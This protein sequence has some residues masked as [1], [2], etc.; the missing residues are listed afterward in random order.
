M[1]S[2]L[3]IPGLFMQ[4]NAQY[5]IPEIPSQEDIEK[6][7][8]QTDVSGTYTNT[9]YGVSVTLPDGWSGMASDFKDPDTG[10]WVTGFQAMDGG[11]AANMDAMQDGK[12]A[13]IM[14][15]ILDKSEDNEP[16]EVTPPTDG[17]EYDFDCDEM[18]AEKIKANGK[19]VMKMQVDCSGDDVTM[20]TRAYHYAT[21]DKIVMIAYSTSPATDFDNHIDIFE[22]SVKTLTVDNLIDVDYIIP[23]DMMVTSTDSD[24]TMDEVHDDTMEETDDS[25]EMTDEEEH[26]EEMMTTE[27]VVAPRKQMQE[28]TA[29][30]DVVC[31][32]G[33]ELML[34]TSTGLAA[35]VKS[36]S[37][38][39]LVAMGW[40]TLA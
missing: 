5:D 23:D 26:D 1:A 17:E 39:K 7:M 32:E 31:N 34:K 33:K 21:A 20:K 4:V 38:S 11:L 16:P 22:D 30:T 12:F 25:M 14:L 27:K 19:D 13:V 8:Q 29:A 9:D 28:G 15:S 40:G 36:S 24:D 3:I 35:C 2:L 10:T 18:T 37:V 6:M